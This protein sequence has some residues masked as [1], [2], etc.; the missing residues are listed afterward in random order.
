[1]LVAGAYRSLIN[2]VSDSWAEAISMG[3]LTYG[4]FLGIGTVVYMAQRRR[5]SG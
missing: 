1:M 2:G 5:R 3:L 4:I